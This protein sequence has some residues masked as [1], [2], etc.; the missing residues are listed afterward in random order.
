MGTLWGN[1]TN[2][3][4]ASVT[5]RCP[6]ALDL[7]SAQCA[8]PE[9]RNGDRHPDRAALPGRRSPCTAIPP[10]PHVVV[11]VE[12]GQRPSRSAISRY[13]A[14]QAGSHARRHQLVRRGDCMCEGDTLLVRGTGRTC[15]GTGNCRHR[16]FSG[17]SLVDRA[18]SGSRDG[19][20]TSLST[21]QPLHDLSASAQAR[22]EEPSRFFGEI[23]QDSPRLDHAERCSPIGRVVAHDRGYSVVG[24]NLKER[25]VE[26]FSGGDV[27][28]PGRVRQSRTS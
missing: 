14:L 2:P 17:Q 15:G 20:C 27:H 10:A 28:R 22:R 26:L 12:D 19:A 6:S 5:D 9:R 1:R 16:R 8:I 18:G 25:R 4:F 3:S 7:S 11:H 24:G 21:E 23:L 13:R